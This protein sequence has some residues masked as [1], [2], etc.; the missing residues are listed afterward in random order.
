M[1]VD[2]EATTSLGT[3]VDPIVLENLAD[4]AP[5]AGSSR[6]CALKDTTGFRGFE[7]DHA[8]HY[9]SL[10]DQPEERADLGDL[11]YGTGDHERDANQKPLSTSAFDPKCPGEPVTRG[12][13]RN[14][15]NS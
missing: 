7:S 12:L 14:P 6:V 11:Y 3:I 13:M 4:L 5:P 1:V 10:E 15:T 8:C 9:M 2:R